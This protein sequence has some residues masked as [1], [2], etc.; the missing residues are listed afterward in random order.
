MSRGMAIF[1][2]LWALPLRGRQRAIPG[3]LYNPTSRALE[4]SGMAMHSSQLARQRRPS[5]R[6]SLHR[7]K[8][9]SGQPRHRHLLRRK[10]LYSVSGP[11]S[12]RWSKWEE[13]LS[14]LRRMVLGLSLCLVSVPNYC[15]KHV[16]SCTMVNARLLWASATQNR[17]S[18][19]RAMA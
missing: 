14:S 4:S 6:R 16:A 12:K 10:A 3:M 13:L 1:T 11:I 8:A 15:P 19:N 17:K 7:L 2:L 18:S 5:R 9:E